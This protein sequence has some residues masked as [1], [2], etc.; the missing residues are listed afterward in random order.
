MANAFSQLISDF[1]SITVVQQ[2]VV[3]KTFLSVEIKKGTSLLKLV[4]LISS[5][6]KG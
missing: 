4:M 2:I 1:E 5:P 6:L 3:I